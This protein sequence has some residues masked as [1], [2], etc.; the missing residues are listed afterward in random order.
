MNALR[1]GSYWAHRY[2][3]VW[4]RSVMPTLLGPLLYLL[5]MGKVLGS[6]IGERPGSVARLDGV[7]YLSFVGPAIVALAALLTASNEA[8]DP[9]FRAMRGG[10]TYL[11]MTSTPLTTGEI[12]AGHLLWMAARVA[13]TSVAMLAVLALLGGTHS[14]QAILLVPVGV[15]VGM[16]VACGVSAFAARQRS[17]GNLL[18]WQRFGV[19]PMM[20][21]AGVYFPVSALPTP[22]Q[23]VVK[24]TPLWHGVELARPLALGTA[25]LGAALPHVVYLLALA[26]VGA[27]IARRS[28]TRELIV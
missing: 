22:V 27:V 12:L 19:V 26:A 25:S 8:S 13:I 18:A 28:F 2:R 11:S 5:V 14:W 10:R 23:A 7:S 16:S 4:R 20:L 21:F 17:P 24:L 1:A 3:K 9:V 6:V 15:L